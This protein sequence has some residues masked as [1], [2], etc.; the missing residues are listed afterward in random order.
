MLRIN[1]WIRVVDRTVH[2]N[3]RD[4]SKGTEL[5][6]PSV[7]GDS[8]HIFQANIAGSIVTFDTD[9]VE[10]RE[11]HKRQRGKEEHDRRK[12]IGR[13]FVNKYTRV[14]GNPNNWTM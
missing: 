10:I 6:S 9:L 8:V 4:K 7:L 1:K 3:Q 12:G 11:E 5:N 14:W 13:V 2:K